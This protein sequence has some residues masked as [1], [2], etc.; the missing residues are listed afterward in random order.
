ML[1]FRPA[2]GPSVDNGRRA[3]G[4]SP[5]G[6]GSC[7]LDFFPSED[8]W[9]TTGGPPPGMDDFGADRWYRNNDTSFGYRWRSTG[10]PPAK[11]GRYNLVFLVSEDGYGSTGGPPVGMGNLG[12]DM[13]IN[14]IDT[15]VA[16]EEVSSLRPMAAWL[17]WGS[18]T[19]GPTPSLG[20]SASYWSNCNKFMPVVVA[21]VPSLEPQ[22]FGMGAFAGDWRIGGKSAPGDGSVAS[23]R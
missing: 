12:A 23:S 7:H 20:D 17:T 5:T 1:I 3:T 13:F 10:G 9:G 11:C 6:C 4:G 22:L 16:M 2:G 15:H 14:G 18:T 8:G 19:G 21:D